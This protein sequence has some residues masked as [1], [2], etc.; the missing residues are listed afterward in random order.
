MLIVAVGLVVF[1][2]F[3]VALALTTTSTPL[4]R[5]SKPANG[6]SSPG[7]GN[8][9]DS[10]IGTS[11]DIASRCPWLK[12]AIGGG[13]SP[14]RLAALVE[15]RMNVHE[16]VSELVLYSDG[17][18]ENINAG[19][20]RLCI[21]SLAVQDGPQGLAY[22]DTNV[23]QL[24]S[25]LGIAATFNTATALAY[26]V[27]EGSE[28][29]GQG[30]D[31]IQG[32]TLNID[33]VPE[34][35]RS[36]E[37]YGEDPVL[38]SAMGVA[39]IDGIQSTGTMAMAKHFAV[40]NQETDRGVLDDQ[41]SE[42]A[43]H[44]LYLPPFKAAVTQAHVGSV[45]CAYPR[46]NGIFQCQQPQLLGLLA[47]WGFTG[48]IRSDLGSVHDPVAAIES[49]IDL[50]KPENAGQLDALVRQG[51]LPLSSVDAAVTRL[52]T[53]MFAHHLVG[54]FEQATLG[55]P[56]DSPAHTHV[57]LTAAEQSAVLLKDHGGVLPLSPAHDRSVALIGADAS[58]APD[59]TG[60]GSSRVTPPFTSDPLSAIR[61]VAGTNTI[62]TYTNGASTTRSLSAVPTSLLRPASGSGHGLT[63]T[64]S[65]T[66]ASANPSAEAVALDEAQSYQLVQP[67]V[68]IAI[69]PHPS[70][71]LFLPGLSPGAPTDQSPLQ[72]SLGLPRR[73]R[74]EFSPTRTRVVLPAGWRNVHVAWTGTLTPPRTGL[75]TLSLQ[76]SGAATLLLDGKAVVSD[77]LSHVLGRWSQAVELTGGHPYQVDM[78]W[79][80]FDNLTPSGESKVVEGDMT[81]GWSYDSGQIAAAV[82]AARTATAAVVFAG[83]FSSEAFDRPS[84]ALPGDE[85]A[86][87]AA[88]AAANPHTVV[89][90]NSG[91]PVLMPWLASVAGVLEAWY[92]GEED[93][94][95]VAALLYGDVDPSGRLPVTFPTSAATSAI[96]TLSQWPGIDLTATY[97]EGLDVGYRYNHATGV[98]P[99]FPFGFGLSYT[100]FRLGRT[101]S[102]RRSS[103]RD[104]LTVRVTNVGK[105]EGTDVV[106]AYL[107]Y[108]AAAGEPPAQLVAF[109][110]VALQPG[111]KRAVTLAVPASSFRVYLNGGWATVP[112]TYTLSVGQSSSDLPLSVTT[113]AP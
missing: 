40:Y 44:E 10:V 63:V 26:G 96:N 89:V 90:I 80:P 2:A 64:I 54:R 30:I 66:D 55:T 83:S 105:R 52:L 38:V 20:P 84:L 82:R 31:A 39:D 5:M 28:A 111:Q 112:G 21:P 72:P 22:G 12:K 27:V 68:D 81:L 42:R 13:G 73:R 8:G 93:G 41:V 36:Y 107:T 101:V 97:S 102:L 19:V 49:G 4:S 108:P 34:S 45:M 17:S 106:Q 23:T 32:P 71:A 33:R 65:R 78:G 92:P 14:A 60:G 7:K 48:F 88:V 77:P 103:R 56:V 87:I 59:T 69:R 50:I 16:K 91:G 24:P 46:L 51:Q 29:R 86:L 37:G 1:I 18:Y 95:A 76:G 25:P 15:D 98:Q 85:N 110:P 70:T 35:G 47:S 53:V 99:L 11:A 109:Y 113:A 104:T 75:Y 6:T 3:L 57:A 94:A 100:R 62:V 9:S 67:T 79:Q 43:L 58:T 61:H 74:E